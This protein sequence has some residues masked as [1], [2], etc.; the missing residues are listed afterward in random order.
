MAW[1]LLEATL[2]A[3]SKRKSLLAGRLPCTEKEAPA[4][5]E[6][7]G[8]SCVSGGINPSFR[9][10]RFTATGNARNC[11]PVMTPLIEVLTISF[12]VIGASGDNFAAGLADAGLAD[13]V[14]ALAAITGAANSLN[15]GK[16]TF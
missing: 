15:G 3:P 2:S 5:G 12:A 9:K 14:T 10:L 7:W 1:L 13:V 11:S 16:T 8:T 4:S 6:P